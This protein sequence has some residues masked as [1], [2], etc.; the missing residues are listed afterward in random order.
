[1][2]P[3]SDRSLLLLLPLQLSALNFSALNAAACQPISWQAPP[4]QAANPI[5]VARAIIS[6]PLLAR[7]PCCTAAL[8]HR[9]HSAG[10]GRALEP[11]GRIAVMARF[12]SMCE[13]NV[14]S[15]FHPLRDGTY[16]HILWTASVVYKHFTIFHNFITVSRPKCTSK[17]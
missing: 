13:H 5:A 4:S 14:I 17:R 12:P 3:A 9:V 11:P 7:A 1:V 8:R 6:L 15:S 2:S 10:K 16:V